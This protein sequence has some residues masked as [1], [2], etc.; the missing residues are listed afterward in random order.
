[1]MA[2]SILTTFCENGWYTAPMDEYPATSDA[3]RNRI[4]IF[5]DDML[6]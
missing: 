3:P 4:R 2:L 1:M 6:S 5:F